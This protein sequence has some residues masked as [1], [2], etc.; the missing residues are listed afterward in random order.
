[1]A[2]LAVALVSGEGLDA[3]SFEDGQYIYLPY[4]K[5]NPENVDT[6]MERSEAKTE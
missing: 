5:V 4:L 2:Q 1:M 3:I 6:F